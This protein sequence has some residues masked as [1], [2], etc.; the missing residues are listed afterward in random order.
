MGHIQWEWE[1][2]TFDGKNQE[3]ILSVNHGIQPAPND[4]CFISFCVE[5]VREASF[6]ND[7]LI[8]VIVAPS[9]I[10]HSWLSL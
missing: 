9:E 10:L 6:S 1:G 4:N 5:N 3:F 2:T 8:E 7:Y